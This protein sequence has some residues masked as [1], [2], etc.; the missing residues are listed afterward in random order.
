MFVLHLLFLLQHTE[1]TQCQTFPMPQ[2]CYLLVLLRILRRCVGRGEVIGGR[3][4]LRDVDELLAD[5]PRDHDIQPHIVQRDVDAGHCEEVHVRGKV[6]HV[7]EDVAELGADAAEAEEGAEP[8]E[9]AED[10][11]LVTL[12]RLMVT[13]RA[14]DSKI[15]KARWGVGVGLWGRGVVGEGG[16]L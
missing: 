16:W 12:D 15:D 4:E 13:R 1:H 11:V 9:E 10:D 5:A 8:V 2:L 3:G 14:V 6:E 7:E